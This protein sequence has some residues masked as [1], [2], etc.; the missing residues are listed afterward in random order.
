MTVASFLTINNN[1]FPNNMT[2]VGGFSYGDVL[3]AG[4]GWG[5][6]IL[7]QTKVADKFLNHTQSVIVIIL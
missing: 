7:H 4:R 3:G 2:S 1:L 6:S 5:S